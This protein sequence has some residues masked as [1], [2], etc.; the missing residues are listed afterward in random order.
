MSTI[1]DANDAEILKLRALSHMVDKTFCLK[2]YRQTFPDKGCDICELEQ[3]QKEH[4]A[5]HA[6]LAREYLTL[7]TENK[8]LTD[9]LQ[10]MQQISKNQG[11][12]AGEAEM[13][14]QALRENLAN[15]CE[16]ANNMGDG[17]DISFHY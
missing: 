8:A 17:N 6:K 11:D 1:Q 15:A 5:G 13:E 16:V 4:N 7:E 10:A 14:L 2:H 3:E 9:E 12:R